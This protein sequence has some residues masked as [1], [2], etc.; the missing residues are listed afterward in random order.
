MQLFRQSVTMENVDVEEMRRMAQMAASCENTQDAVTVVEDVDAG[1]VGA[2]ALQKARRFRFDRDID[3]ALIRIVN[4]TGAHI[5][6]RGE[7][8]KLF[9]Q[10]H[11]MLVDS[12]ECKARSTAMGMVEPM[13]RS[14]RE[15]FQGLVRSR[16]KAIKKNQSSSGISEKHGEYE[17]TL[18]AMILAMDEKKSEEDAEKNAK[19]A[20]E[21]KL[22]KRGAEMREAACDVTPRKRQKERAFRLD[23]GG[24][25]AELEAILKEAADNR[26]NDER[27]I[28][29]EERR[30]ALDE[31]RLVMEEAAR[32]DQADQTKAL[33]ALL[34]AF[35]S[36][37][38]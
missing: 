35:A 18:D 17:K 27:R 34:T 29:L 4:D 6:A 20:A 33:T 22:K 26:K 25:E 7:S 19:S 1:D 36:K 16:R 15:R 37:M 24:G 5:P 8:E 23:H 21:E 11:K 2:G 12:H 31:R 30:M 3:L 28:A 38:K 13:C 10:V 32:K 14:V 9:Q